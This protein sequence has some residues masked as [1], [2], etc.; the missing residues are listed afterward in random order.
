M[1]NAACIDF[2]RDG[3]SR[4]DVADKKVLEVGAYDVNGSLRSLIASLNP[5]SYLGIDIAPGPGVDEVCDVAE[6]LAR[7]GPEA[8]DVVIATEVMEHVRDWRTAIDNMKGV[9]RPAGV[10]LITTR[11][12]GFGYHGYPHDYWRYQ[13]EDMRMMFADFDTLTVQHDPSEPGVFLRAVKP[14][15]WKRRSLDDIQ[16]YS[17]VA[18]RRVRDVGDFTVLLGRLVFGIPLNLRRTAGRVLPGR[19]KRALGRG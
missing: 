19:L 1:C 13:P 11:S 16:L 12:K 8:F 9:L 6:A 18:R 10:I 4:D 15:V 17:I 2:A 3:L 7:Y 14:E 5:G